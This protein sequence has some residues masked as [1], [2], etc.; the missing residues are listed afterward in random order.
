LDKQRLIEQLR[1]HEGVEHKP[2]VDTVGKTTI[3][4]GRNLDDVGL[5]DD[6]IDYLLDNDIHTVMSELDVWWDGWRELDE[7]RQRVLADMMFNMGRPTLNKFENF[8]AALVDGNYEQASVEML[9]SRWAEQVGQRAERL[10]G[11]MAT[12]EDE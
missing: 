1:L 3:G 10:A 9:D 11:M 2:Y 8:H 7:V 6:E 12:G 4:V 5:T